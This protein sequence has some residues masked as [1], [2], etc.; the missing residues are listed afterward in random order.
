MLNNENIISTK[1]IFDIDVEVNV[2]NQRF[3]LKH[4]LTSLD[5][6]L[7]IS[8]WMSENE[9]YCY[10]VYFVHYRLQDNWNKIKEDEKIFYALNKKGSSLV[11]RMFDL[12]EKEIKID[13]KTRT[14]RFDVETTTFEIAS[15]KIFVD[16]LTQKTFAYVVLMSKMRKSKEML[17]EIDSDDD[18]SKLHSKI[19][20][21]FA[22]IFSEQ[23]IE[24]LSK[25]K[26]IDHV[27]DT[28]DRM[29]SHEFLYN[30]FNNELNVLRKYLND[31]L[32][33]RWIRHFI[34]LASVLILFVSKKDEELK[35]CVDYRD[36]NKIIVKNR[37]LLSLITKTLNRLCEAKWFFKI[38]LKNVYHRMRIKAS[39]EWKTTFRTRYDHFEYLV[40]SFELANASATF[41]SYINKALTELVNRFCVIY[42]NDILIFLEFEEE[43][44]SH[45]KEILERLRQYQ[46][47]AKLS[48][49]QFFTT[50]V[51]F[52]RF[53]ISIDDV[54]MNSSR[55]KAI[56]S[57]FT[58]KTYR[59]VQVFLRFVNFYKRFVYEYSRIA[60]FLID[61]LQE[62]KN[63]V[64]T[65]SFLW[66]DDATKAFDKLREIFI[67]ISILI[68]FNFKLRIRMKIDAS[69]F[70]IAN[71]LSQLQ[72]NEQWH[73]ITFWFKKMISIERD[74]K[75]YDQEFLVIVMTF[76]QWRYY[77]KEN[78]YLVEVLTDHNNLRE[79]MNV[80]ELNSR[81]TR[82]AMKLISFDFIIV[83]RSRKTNFTNTSSRRSNYEEFKTIMKILLFT[84]QNKL[85]MLRT[86][87]AKDMFLL[88]KACSKV[89]FELR[90]K[91]SQSRI[92][93]L[94]S[95]NDE[96]FVYIRR[97]LESFSKMIVE[98]VDCK[99][100][101]SR[102]IIV[103]LITRET[104][105]DFLSD[106]V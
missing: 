16:V 29:F 12:A 55:V 56:A 76:K 74:Y 43:H 42:L 40:M 47:Y 1:I 59:E 33:K 73:L 78:V 98:I 39:D 97:D 4:E 5:V 31:V 20:S 86:L 89:T 19:N 104:I 23:E 26:N 60:S 15:S 71:I 102:V 94:E 64:K 52:L 37:H 3:V 28:K 45:V 95:N 99:Q 66:F 72:K 90:L 6:K 62:N 48:K 69:N 87:I 18:A 53:I 10:D 9:I 36:L 92:E 49:C 70:A 50:Q 13:I 22:N 96:T 65:K 61:L 30:L 8:K 80:K 75:I 100:F 101:V 83:H 17:D 44:L 103:N 25:H 32:A 46:L 57:W 58:S 14:W 91:R 7:F 79:F 88:K 93:I 35:L 38:D 54:T 21:K 63:E 27:I 68:H 41:Q 77:V 82:W 84:L 67:T 106:F 24:R 34:N 11:L 105:Y 2:I 81:Q 51:E 85:F